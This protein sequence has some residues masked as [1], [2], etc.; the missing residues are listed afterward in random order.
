MAWAAVD[1]Q[2]HVARLQLLRPYFCLIPED[3]LILF[4]EEITS[5]LVLLLQL[6]MVLESVVQK[7]CECGIIYRKSFSY[8][9]NYFL[10]YVWDCW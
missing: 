10:S 5:G 9:L 7:S 3:Y 1:V 6:Q 2:R 8:S 4:G